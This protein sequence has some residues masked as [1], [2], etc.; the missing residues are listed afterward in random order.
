M[1]LSYGAGQFAGELNV[2]TGQ[3][4][5]LAVRAATDGVIGRISRSSFRQLMA[6]EGDLS[7]L[8]L[9]ALLAR[10]RLLRQNVDQGLRIVGEARSGAG[11][12]LRT[13][14]DRQGLAH[15]WLEPTSDEADRVLA[16]AGAH[17]SDLPL[18]TA[19]TWVLRKVTPASLSEQLGLGV[20]TSPPTVSDLVVIGAGPA[21][22]A[23]AVYGASEGL[24]TVLLDAVATGGQ[25]AT[26]ARIENFLGFPFGVSGSDLAARAAVQALKFGTRI[27]SP[28]R[29][30]ALGD[31]P[32]GHVV[33]LGDGTRLDTRAV[34]VASGAEFGACRWSAGRSSPGPASTTPP[35]T[36]RPGPERPPGGRRGRSE[37]GRPGRAEARPGGDV[38]DPRREGSR[39]ARVDVVLPGR[40]DR[41]R[42]PH[43]RADG[44]R[45]RRAARDRS[46]RGRAASRPRRHAR[47]AAHRL[48]RTV[49]LRRRGAG[50]LVA[51]GRRA[52]RRRVRQDRRCAH[53]GG[54]G[55][56][57]G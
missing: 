2:L 12:A 16:T 27:I 6:R 24:S 55:P 4:R 34:V 52:G 9:R 50:D 15:A 32:L 1:F 30:T 26:S 10:R 11:M 3:T 18:A 57:L 35:P 17:R 29:V 7:D 44:H 45:G 28:C 51:V 54:P 56:A 47:P 36:W 41:G 40:A 33:D 8:V 5:T 48:R 14:L 37:L 39:R 49:L 20:G 46:A 43:R 38:G 19:S 13:F 22:L 25:A 21:G 31:G 23:A 53:D 42:G